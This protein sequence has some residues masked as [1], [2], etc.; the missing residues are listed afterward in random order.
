MGG[1]TELAFKNQKEEEGLS[2][3]NSLALP[4]HQGPQR[5]MEDPTSAAAQTSFRGSWT[6]TQANLGLL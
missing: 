6:D 2:N 1:R 5:V 3:F 4:V